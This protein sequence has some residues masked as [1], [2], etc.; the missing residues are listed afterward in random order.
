MLFF[1]IR[2]PTPLTRRSETWRERLTA[3]PKSSLRLSKEK[4]KSLPRS[5]SVCAMSAFRSNDFEGIQPTFKQTP[6]SHCLSTIATFCLSCEARI[7]ATYPAGPAPITT[8]S[9]FS[10]IH[11]SSSMSLQGLSPSQQHEFIVFYSTANVAPGRCSWCMLFQTSW[12][13]MLLRVESQVDSS[14]ECKTVQR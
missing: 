5:R 7:A 8:T 9:K 14:K 6:P 12:L 2:K 11:F 4:P 10:A 3:T 1:F 13:N